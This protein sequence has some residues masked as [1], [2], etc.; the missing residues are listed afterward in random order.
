MCAWT[1]VSKLVA[2]GLV[3]PVPHPTNDRT[4]GR[5]RLDRSDGT[6]PM[7]Q[8]RA[9]IA[10]LLEGD[11]PR[12][13]L[14]GRQ[15]HQFTGARRP[16]PGHVYTFFHEVLNAS[17]DQ[18]QRTAARA[19]RTLH[20]CRAS[21]RCL[22]PEGIRRKGA[23]RLT[24]VLQESGHADWP[25]HFDPR[26]RTTYSCGDQRPSLYGSDQSV[27]IVSP[28]PPP[29]SHQ[30]AGA[31]ITRQSSS[32][33]GGDASYAGTAQNNCIPG[34]PDRTPPAAPRVVRA[35]NPPALI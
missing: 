26:R 10:I 32:R 7:T 23:A 17:N 14:R 19:G 33:I 11:Q 20:Y 8:R 25:A 15:P 4:H 21:D 6:L 5:A 28:A 22:P 18:N 13:D 35:H 34:R 2:A 29:R 12:R 3:A 27:Y 31:S 16:R 24:N 9:S 30:P 1:F